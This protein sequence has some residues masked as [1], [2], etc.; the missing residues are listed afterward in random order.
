[1]DRAIIFVTAG[2]WQVPAIKMA[3]ELGF[4]SIAIDSNPDAPGL[5]VADHSIIAELDNIKEIIGSIDSLSL[6]H[7]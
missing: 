1:M 5:K 6:I 3:M 4:C 2:R 7:I